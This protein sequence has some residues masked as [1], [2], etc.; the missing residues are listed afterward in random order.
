MKKFYEVPEVE[1]HENVF[2]VVMNETE[3]DGS[4]PW[5]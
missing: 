2:E 5:D 1:I 4:N 3:E